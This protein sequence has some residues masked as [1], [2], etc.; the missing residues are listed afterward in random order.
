VCA[1]R[2]LDFVKDKEVEEEE[3]D[4]DE[5]CRISIADDI[6]RGAG[7][8]KRERG[9]YREE[10]NDCM[11]SRR[12]ANLV[13]LVDRS[14]SLAFSKNNDS[15]RSIPSPHNCPSYYSSLSCLLSARPVIKIRPSNPTFF[16]SLLCNSYFWIPSKSPIRS[17]LP[18]AQWNSDD[19]CPG[20]SPK[21]FQQIWQCSEFPTTRALCLPIAY[22]AQSS[23]FPPCTLPH[24]RA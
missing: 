5:E 18:D 2:L 12:N 17:L 24:N 21:L 6:V 16:V 23:E 11:V 9:D 14:Q 1:Y 15:C 8:G 13:R 22:A 3:K 4:E 19:R 20:V 7:G 10:Y